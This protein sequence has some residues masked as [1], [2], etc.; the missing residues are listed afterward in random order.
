[1][2]TFEEGLYI[3]GL[4]GNIEKLL[5][6]IGNK[7]HCKGC[8]AEIWWIKTKKGKNMPVTNK[9]LPHHIDCPKAE[10]FRKKK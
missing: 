9:A 1:M 5:D 6:M 8:G 2:D 7:S 3:N 4:I 10:Q